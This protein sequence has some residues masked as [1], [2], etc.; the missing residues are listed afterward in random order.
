MSL[1]PP[2]SENAHFFSMTDE[3]TQWCRTAIKPFQLEGV[4]WKTAEHYFQAMRF[5][6]EDYRE[7]I[8]LSNSTQDAVKLGNSWFKKKKS[9]WKKEQMTLM[10]RALYTQ[11]QIYPEMKQAILETGEETLVENSQ[12]DYF[13][14]CGRDRRGD[15]CYG[16]ILMNI[17]EKLSA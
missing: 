15:N 10:T 4:E 6:S 2:I 11:C 12:F 8:R 9:N 16:R 3:S 1:F 14:G 5:E 13:W 7:K 17:R